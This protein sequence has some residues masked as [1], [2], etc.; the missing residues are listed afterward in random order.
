[1][2]ARNNG[3]P[4]PF[5]VAR[6][7]LRTLSAP[8]CL[9]SRMVPAGMKHVRCLLLLLLLGGSG[10]VQAQTTVTV[11][12]FVT[13]A[14]EEIPLVG[15]NVALRGVGEVLYG[16]VT[17]TDGFYQIS[18][19]PR[20]R[21]VLRISYVGYV[22]Y[23]DTLELGARAFQTL[24]VALK[25][26]PEELE[27][28]VVETEQGA[29]TVA[30]GAQTI[31]P[32]DLG[33][34]PTPDLSG[35][36]ASYLQTLPGIVAIGDRGGQLFVRGGTASQNLVLVDGVLVYQPFHIVG[37]FSAFPQDLVASADFY[38]GGFGAR[39]SGRVSSVLDITMREGNR[40]RYRASASASPFLVSTLVE[41]PLRR[42]KSSFLASARTSVI[43]PLAPTLLGQD[44]PLRF[45]DAFV[46][47]H[48]AGSE[49]S[50]CSAS[51]LYTADRGTVEPER[52]DALRWKNLVVGGR[53]IAFPS[54]QAV[55]FEANT[56]LSYVRNSAGVA[57][58]PERASETFQLSTEFNLTRY[59]RRAELNMGFFVRANW[60]GY[61]LQ[62]QFQNVRQDNQTFFG[63]GGYFEAQ[64]TL[65]PRLALTPGVVLTLYPDYG[66]HLEPRLRGTF[67]PGGVEGKLTVNGAAGL[68]RQVLVGLSDERDAGSVFTAWVP[69]PV[70]GSQTQAL[71][72]LLGVQ[73]PL[74]R[75]LQVAAEGYYKRIDDLAVPI[76]STIARFTTALTLAEG[77]VYGLDTRVEW[78]K[79]PFYAYVGYGL[80][81]TVYTASQENFGVWFGEPIQSYT[82][83]HDQRH[84]VNALVSFDVA[85]VQ[86]SVRW[87]FGSGL[88]FT[89]PFGF[90][91]LIPLNTFIDVRRA[92]PITRVL[93]DRPYEGRLP[94]YHRL[95]V[96]LERSFVHNEQ[97]WTVQAGA[98]NLY[99]RAN[100]F[101]YDVFTVRRVNQLPLVPFV[102]LK[103]ESR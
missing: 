13:D 84:Q 11:R 29:A 61:D 100:L 26:T 30:G 88:P 65:S 38:A 37:F 102:S 4:A 97:R 90:D 77:E 91:D 27:E 48:R 66:T 103:L 25:P 10:W 36:L 8:G 78:R 1:M 18:R 34:I 54:D 42:G 15:A 98:I 99:D 101:Y 58:S 94:P 60:L 87:Q 95:D 23:T 76:W 46:K 68:Y 64:M 7:V 56:G 72:A 53:C 47:L 21:Y 44:L 82:P 71:H 55:F 19:V 14:E 28:V 63:A 59:L 32:A 2:T 85:Q 39:Y 3:A 69:T 40:E 83:P 57:G 86:A 81:R 20:G 33:R 31:R 41:G 75:H 96:S 93:F 73:R 62:E 51:A 70:E 6:P 17:N 9:A 50:R 79:K 16:A 89:R 74:G 67:K 92:S 22:A 12:G 49:N 45:S 52:D 43:E 5:V 80:S 35:D 24:N